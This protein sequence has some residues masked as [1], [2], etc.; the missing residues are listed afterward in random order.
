MRTR[1]AAPLKPPDVD[2][3]LH[4]FTSTHHYESPINR[5]F[6]SRLNLI[7]SLSLSNSLS[8]FL[9]SLYGHVFESFTLCLFPTFSIRS[10]SAPTIVYKQ[11][12]DFIDKTSN[13]SR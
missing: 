13:T 6:S 12:N 7:F 3:D 2:I 1:E 11:T 10:A 5:K 4:R 8:L 9:T